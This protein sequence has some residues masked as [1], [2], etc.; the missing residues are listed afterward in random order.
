M[1][2]WEKKIA[3][4]DEAWW[5]QQL[6]G[7]SNVVY[8]A[9]PG[10]S[11]LQVQCYCQ[12]AVEAAALLS[13]FGGK[14]SEL[15]DRD[16]VAATAPENTPPL[17]IRNRLVVVSS[18]AQVQPMQQR[19]PGRHVLCFPA[20]RAFGTGNHGTTAT[21]LRMLCDEARARRGQ[22]WRVIDVG[23]GTGILGLAALQLGARNALCFDFDASAVEVAQRNLRR[24][25]ELPGMRVF[26]ADVFE[27]TPSES[28]RAEVVVANLFS[29]LL[30]KAFPR[31]HSYLSCAPGGVLIVSGILREQAHDTLSAAQR[32]GFSLLRQAVCG[33]W[34]SMK[35]TQ[36]T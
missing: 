16:W 24:N 3:Q 20:E 22:S 17:M 23:C 18:P 15:E 35:L 31:L 4:K 34:V 32:A 36:E 10:S 1:W 2:V 21:C 29:G 25:G 8:T 9:M 11:C 6:T 30:Q 27:W 26:Q 28:E 5:V 33:K 7:V 12:N 14:M 13:A 19:Y